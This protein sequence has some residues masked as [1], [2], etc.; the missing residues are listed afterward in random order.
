MKYV[1][2]EIHKKAPPNAYITKSDLK[3]GYNVSA[4]GDYKNKWIN[5]IAIAQASRKVFISL[6][7]LTKR[8]K[9]LLGKVNDAII[10]IIW[11]FLDVFQSN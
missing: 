8:E 4:N 7:S 2:V 5:V 9:I 1:I 11:N 10:L 3:N 6:M